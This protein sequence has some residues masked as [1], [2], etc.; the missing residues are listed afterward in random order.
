[1]E[2]LF[3]IYFTSTH[4]DNNNFSF[5]SIKTMPYRFNKYAVDYLIRGIIF[6]VIRGLG[7][8]KILVN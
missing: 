4:N 3:N 7:F 5:V 6:L 2:Q 8:A 1:M